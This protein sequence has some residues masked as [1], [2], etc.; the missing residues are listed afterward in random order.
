MKLRRIELIVAMLWCALVQAQDAFPTG[1][2]VGGPLTATFSKDG[3]HIVTENGRTVVSGTYTIKADQIVLTDKA[4]EY[5]CT[6]TGTYQ[7]GFDGTALTFK[8]VLD[9]CGPRVDSLTRQKWIRK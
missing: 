7:W 4:G 8:A 2:F 5:T 6:E 1:S 3:T 9:N